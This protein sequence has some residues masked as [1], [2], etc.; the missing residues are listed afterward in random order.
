MKEKVIRD[1]LRRWLMEEHGW[2]PQD[3]ELSADVLDQSLRDPMDGVGTNQHMRE[4][5]G[6]GMLTQMKSDASRP[7]KI[8]QAAF[9][10]MK[11]EDNL[12]ATRT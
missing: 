2:G 6:L 12:A 4:L 5:V 1:A 7:C 8:P 3:P 10:I 11:R 9:D